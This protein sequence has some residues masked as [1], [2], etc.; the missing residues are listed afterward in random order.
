[1]SQFI[2]LLYLCCYL[3]KKK[4]QL[5][6]R[7]L[8]EK[9]KQKSDFTHRAWALRPELCVQGSRLAAP[10][11]R[12]PSPWCSCSLC[13]PWDQSGGRW[14]CFVFIFHNQEADRTYA[15]PTF[16][17]T[18]WT[19]SFN[20]KRFSPGEPCWAE[21]QT[22]DSALFLWTSWLRTCSG[23]QLRTLHQHWPRGRQKQHRREASEARSN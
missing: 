20:V 8:F 6:K 16:T 21:G 1:M 17:G 7:R 15:I 9:K 5:R 11:C 4:K 22:P 12:R 19:F 14:L 13:F 3:L 18:M 10:F 23:L 2:N